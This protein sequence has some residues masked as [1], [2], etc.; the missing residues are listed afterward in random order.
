MR[1]VRWSAHALDAA[2]RRGV[3]LEWALRTIGDPDEVQPD[4]AHGIR[5]RAFRRIPEFGGRVLRV[6]YEEQQGTIVIVTVV[7]D[8]NAGRRL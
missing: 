4:P 5:T 8:R 6:V 2:E 1:E 3:Q 7:W